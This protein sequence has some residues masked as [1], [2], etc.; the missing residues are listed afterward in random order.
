LPAAVAAVT[1]IWAVSANAAP[2]V[3]I[4]LDTSGAQAVLDA[5]LAPP[6]RA[7]AAADAALANP[8]VQAM[9]AKMAKY[10]PK[11]SAAAFRAAVIEVANGG[12]GRP[13]D[14]ARLPKDPEPTRR[15]LARLNGEWPALSARL[16]GRLS[17]FAPDDL[18]MKGRLE[19][20]AGSNQN[21]WAP[22]PRQPV[23]Y[24][25]LGFHGEEVDS[26]IN[27]AAHELF[28]TV[29]GMSRSDWDSAFADRPDLP[30]TQRELHRA[31]AVV[32]N[33]VLEGMATYVGD[34]T[35]LPSSGPNLKRDQHEIRRNLDR[36][37]EIFALFETVL[38]RARHDPDARLDPLLDI[39]FGGS[40]EQTGYYVG[41]RMAQIIDRYQGR[42]RLRAMVEQD[43]EAFLA[44]YAEAAAAHPDDP[45]VVPL[46]RSTLQ[47]LA[48]LR[49]AEGHMP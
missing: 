46:S 36:A 39:G 45:D 7:R 9:I 5:A 35:R 41:Y 40:W 2:Q 48:D 49:A 4:A 8:A 20:V 17:D 23:F 27:T 10:D 42:D 19:V 21:G 28:H 33:L 22:D 31:H 16:V 38:F 34:P 30:A 3:D 44:A 24:I 32:Y 25:D 14:L 6:A 47:T 15:M 37:P 26:L 11:V 43:P 12:E 29:Q 1:L 18:K 13:F